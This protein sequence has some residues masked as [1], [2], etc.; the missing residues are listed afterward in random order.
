[1]QLKLLG[2]SKAELI[3]QAEGAA[4]KP[5]P[6]QSGQGSGPIKAVF[7]DVEARASAPGT[8][9]EPGD[10]LASQDR[11]MSLA[12]GIMQAGHSCALVYQNL[13]VCAHAVTAHGQ[14]LQVMR[15]GASQ[16]WRNRVYAACHKLTYAATAQHSGL[17]AILRQAYMCCCRGL[18]FRHAII[19]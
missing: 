11:F 5:Q 2:Q 14:V 12:N 18:Q 15:E 10:W 19:A 3:L 13:F 9:V 17:S 6:Q 4:E 7:Q 8:T 1:M 16:A